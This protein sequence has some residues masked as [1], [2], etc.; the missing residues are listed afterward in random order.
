VRNEEVRRSID[1]LVAL[2]AGYPRENP[3]VAADEADV[4]LLRSYFSGEMYKVGSSSPRAYTADLRPDW[5]GLPWRQPPGLLQSAAAQLAR[6]RR[7]PYDPPP[8]PPSLQAI[9]ACTRS[10]FT[11]MKRRLAS[12]TCTGIFYMERPFF[13]VD[14]ELKV[15]MMQAV[16][17]ALPGVRAGAGANQSALPTRHL[18]HHHRHRCCPEGVAVVRP[19]QTQE[20]PPPLLLLTLPPPCPPPH[21][22]GA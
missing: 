13:D 14:V 7:L 3:E 16:A 10:T 4:G 1:D 5:H 6:Q 9:L 22:P 18:R 17:A 15:T 11:A 20:A 8:P 21:P 12:S 2:A 19:L